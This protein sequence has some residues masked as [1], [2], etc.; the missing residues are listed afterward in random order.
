MKVKNLKT[1]EWPSGCAYMIADEPKKTF[2]PKDMFLKAEQKT[3]LGQL[4][5]TKGKNPDN[6]ATAI[7]G[8]E[9]E[10]RIKISKE[11]TISTL[12]SAVGPFHGEAIVDNMEK[13][14]NAERK[15]VTCDAI[16]EKLCKVYRA[17]GSGKGIVG[18]P[19]ETD[20]A[21]PGYFADTT[22]H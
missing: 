13:L 16:V 15:E 9:V 21:D 18:D 20:L 3:K 19:I 8:P 5:Y 1:K 22:C 6:F 4:K 11:D 10:Y 17:T 7:G 14:E 2:R 12:L